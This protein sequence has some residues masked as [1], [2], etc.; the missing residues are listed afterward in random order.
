MKKL[1]S[2]ALMAPL[3]TGCGAETAALAIGGLEVYN[4]VRAEQCGGKL[5]L[6]CTRDAVMARKG[7]SDDLLS[8]V[9]AGDPEATAELSTL[10]QG[11][12]ATAAEAKEKL[13]GDGDTE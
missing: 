5:L 2:M 1:A 3:L 7:A 6:E 9:K 4:S 12:R 13:G 8:R 10:L 11:L